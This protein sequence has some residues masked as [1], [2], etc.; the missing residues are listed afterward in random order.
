MSDKKPPSPKQDALL[1]GALYINHLNN[2]F[3][4]DLGQTNENALYSICN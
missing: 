3:P 2:L 1:N 4:F